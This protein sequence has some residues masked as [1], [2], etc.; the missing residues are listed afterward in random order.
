MADQPQ[1]TTDFGFRTVARDE[2]QAMVADVFHSVAAKYDVMNDLMSFGIHRVWKRFTIDCS[3]VRRGQRVLD[4]A[5]GTGDLAAK[6]S[7]M[8]G[9]Q[10]QVVLA[11]I[12]DSML[13]MGREKLRDRG[14]IGNISYVQ[15]NAEALP[16]PDN[17][18]DCITISFGLRNV[19]DKDKALRSMFRVLKPGGRLLV[20]EFSKPLLAPLRKAYDAYSFHVLPKI[21]ELVV[22]D[23]ESY[24]YLAESI[25]MH[26]DQETLKGMMGTAGFDNVTYFN[27]TGGIVALHRGFKF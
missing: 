2:K 10:G 26:P 21:G 19:T 23:P 24:R 22:K 27:L 17:Y 7:R 13:K 8:V 20:L 11:D 5:G 3:G 1:E 9:E 25:R 14:I 4:L 15:A 12:N 18:F 6:F 16:F